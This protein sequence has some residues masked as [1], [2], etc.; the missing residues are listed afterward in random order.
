MPQDGASHND[1]T[2]L[3]RRKNVHRA[4]ACI[5]TLGE[6]IVGSIEDRFGK[7]HFGRLRD[8]QENP[9]RSQLANL[10]GE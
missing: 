6:N 2:A 4:L 8:L 10:K 5:E 9:G 3:S 7:A 1:A